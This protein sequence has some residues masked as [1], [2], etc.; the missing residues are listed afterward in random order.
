[1]EV[2]LL[3]PVVWTSNYELWGSGWENM[4]TENEMKVS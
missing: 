2:T 3:E 4:L 1:M